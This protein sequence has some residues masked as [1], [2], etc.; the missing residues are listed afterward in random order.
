MNIKTKRAI[1]LLILATMLFATIPTIPVH[2]NGF[3]LDPT[4][5]DKGDEVEA[6]G[7]GAAG[8]QIVEL[9]WDDTTHAWDGE[10]GL[11]GSSTVD[12][13]GT[14]DVEFD[15]PEATAGTHYVYAVV[16]GG[17]PMGPVNF[18]VLSKVSLGASSGL[19]G[20]DLDV[21]MYG[22][23]EEVNTAIF[24]TNYTD[25][26][27]PPIDGEGNE[28]L[29]T[30]TADEPEYDGEVDYD[31]IV[32]GTFNI[33]VNGTFWI[34]D[35]GAG[36]LADT[37]VSGS[38]DY[39]TGEWELDW[40]DDPVV[41][42]TMTCEYAYYEEDDSG[43]DQ[44]YVLSSSAGK[45]DVV[46]SNSKTVEIPDV[47]EGDYCVYVYDAEGNWACA[48][49]TVGPVITLL[50]DEVD[51][52]D[53]LR[54]NGKGFYDDD[55]VDCVEISGGDIETPISCY[56]KS[57][58]SIVSGTF[59]VTVF[60][61]Q[62]PE[63]EEDYTITVYGDCCGE[64]SAD[65]TVNE[66]ASVE[67]DP[68]YGPQL[69][70]IEISGVNFANE[71]G[72]T[73]YLEINDDGVWDRNIT[74]ELE[75][76][77]DGSFSGTFRISPGED[78]NFDV[79]AY[80]H[81]DY[82]IEADAPIRIGSMLVLLS[83][84]EGPTGEM[85]MVY[86]SGFT[87]DG[88]W[89]CT[90]GDIQVIDGSS[91]GDDETLEEGTFYVPNLP[92]G[93]YE[94]I[95]TDVDSEITVDTVY[96]ITESATLVFDPLEAPND[97][98]VSITGENWPQYVEDIE[99]V[100]Y[101]DTDLWTMDVYNE[102]TSDMAT[103]DTDGE[104]DA[105]WEVLSD[106]YLSLG[107]YT[108]N[109]TFLGDEDFSF[110]VD[111]VVGEVHIVLE[112][113]KSTFRVDDVVSFKLEHSFGN[114]DPI[115]GGWLEIFDPDGNLYWKSDDLETWTKVEAWYV[116]PTSGQTAS[117]APMQILDDA[118]LGTW[119]YEW[120]DTEDDEPI[121]EGTFDVTESNA[122]IINQKI[123]DINSA[124]DTLS[125]EIQGV[126]DAVAS[127]N[128][129]IA[130]AIAAANA[131]TAAANAATDAVNA[132]ADTA[133]DAVTAA[134]EA[135]TAAEDARR[136]SGSLTTLVYGAIGA[137]LV[138]ALAAIVSLMQISRRIAG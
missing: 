102:G 135:K 127:A 43:G 60:V 90:F 9:Y 107:A 53:Q 20:D 40:D 35:D 128:D 106:E 32:P 29:G 28:T 115:Y 13:D 48:E 22:Y 84:E 10:S 80:V 56:I 97:Y 130:D 122:D 74:E 68:E 71:N 16:A 44:L 41:V 123:E 57:G 39:I 99:F 103:T 85:V 88:T 23:G 89:D 37:N 72:L 46:G 87:A 4:S 108:V 105:E 136:A 134:N 47:S 95:I 94:V 26:P 117:G 78:G 17:D 36:G 91:V 119:S 49:F 121:E 66:L 131:A 6:S 61:P 124:I 14:W 3:S 5:G 45:T 75:T 51:V 81:P 132:I 58:G 64:A 112:P 113:R 38:I 101:N 133:S 12:P 69:S 104:V 125:D 73:V 98:V 21:S 109:V 110:T 42:G 50:D 137:S 83:S 116:V 52:G 33:T 120:W 55:N 79:N 31:L 2:A 54:I 92:P 86:G 11:I 126:S 114:T 93:V 63:G 34:W 111:F 65:V 1:T 8:G 138:A 19:A 76:N 24:F 96:E 7:G 67:I 25:R 27:L 100:L 62:V 70:T 18:E 82:N 129:D 59:R 118:P 15:V 77:S 30:T